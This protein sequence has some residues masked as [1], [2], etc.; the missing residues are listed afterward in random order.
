MKKTAH[1]SRFNSYI[2]ALKLYFAGIPE[3]NDQ[4]PTGDS[5]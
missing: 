3:K 2:V 5:L 4:K 1:I